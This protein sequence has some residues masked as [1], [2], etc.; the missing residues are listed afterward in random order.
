[1]NFT[2]DDLY[3]YLSPGYDV[4]V[5]EGR[6]SFKQAVGRI[7]ID[8]R[9]KA[10]T[11]DSI[12]S[13]VENKLTG[14][15]KDKD[16][17]DYVS[18]NFRMLGYGENGLVGK[19]STT[20]KYFSKCNSTWSINPLI[21]E[22]KKKISVICIRD[23]EVTPSSEGCDK[24]GRFLNY[25]PSHVAAQMIPYL[26]LEFRH[27]GTARYTR[28]P[29][30]LRFLL[31][32]V[33]ENSLQNTSDLVMHQG[34]KLSEGD[35]AYTRTG[36]EAFLMP[37][38]LT[39]MDTLGM[40][41]ETK[42]R[43]S[44]VKPF[45]PL[46]SI[47][48]F[49]ITARNAGAKNFVHKTASLK[50]KIHDKNRL[51]EFAEFIRGGDGFRRVTIIS[52]YGWRATKSSDPFLQ[53]IN[54]EVNRTD[55][56]AVVN[57][58]FSFDS[59]GQV[60][61]VLQLVS[62]AARYLG[63]TNIAVDKRLDPEGLNKFNETIR[64]ITSTLEE[65]KIF[66]KLPENAF[67]DKLLQEATTTGIYTEKN[68]GKIDTAID[69]YIAILKKSERFRG[70]PGG[71]AALDEF[72]KQLKSLGKGAN[73]KQETAFEKAQKSTK[74]VIEDLFDKITATPDPWLPKSEGK[75]FKPKL[76]A[77]TNK[78]AGKV[79]SFAKLFLYFSDGLYED[80]KE[81]QF[82]FY[83]INANAGYAGTD[84]TGEAISVGEFP[85]DLDLLKMAYRARVRE[86]NTVA[87]SVEEFF[88]LVIDQNFSDTRGIGF[89]KSSYYTQISEDK[90]KE[91][92]KVEKA[93]SDALKKWEQ[94]NPDFVV[95]LLEIE[96]KEEKSTNG[97]MVKRVYVYDRQ[98]S[99][100]KKDFSSFSVDEKKIEL[101][102]GFPLLKIGTNGSLVINSSVSSKTDGAQGAV[103]LQRSLQT[104]PHNPGSSYDKSPTTNPENNLPMRTLPVQLTMTSFGCPIAGLYQQYFV[105][106]DTGTSLDNL[107]MLTQLQHNITPGKFVSSWTF[108][109]SNGYSKFVPPKIPS[110]LTSEI[111]EALK[112]GD[113]KVKWS[114]KDNS[115][116]LD[117]VDR[118][119]RS[120]EPAVRAVT[121]LPRTLAAAATGRIE[122]GK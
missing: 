61:V 94:E 54:N 117:L 50:L 70:I 67:V 24:I 62:A 48:A 98:S 112:S 85:I 110:K 34:M 39:N 71:S 49:D 46:A 72:G 64:S 27:E 9:G 56:W 1:M 10:Y 83:P 106:F 86:L 82:V 101:Q 26:E 53:F 41:L 116:P 3:R 40:K 60:N 102:R 33:D 38:S 45:M 35:S 90:I 29:G 113:G 96:I 2:L 30:I 7:L 91:A 80:G 44:S 119:K 25:T 81:L 43:L 68:S 19:M 57:S 95:P 59:T 104:Q 18:K 84:D 87:L 55:A 120:I 118:I 8:A 65:L 97:T 31:G 75:N 58:Q 52:R 13:E 42:N 15:Q 11:W 99:P 16:T 76:V 105:D 122:P 14:A 114:A 37:Q 89:G 74:K 6:E 20:D 36:M 28:T 107:Y 17:I 111:A 78:K 63:S 22:G 115:N 121:G 4:A 66:G 73:G 100:Y 92:P 47:E 32:V 79:V 88:R 23:Q 103:Y 21:K 108:M 5:T 109:Q 93:Q 12:K 77:V 51:S 69:N